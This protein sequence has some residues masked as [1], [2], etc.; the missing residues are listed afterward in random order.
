MLPCHRRNLTNRPMPR[1]KPRR[2]PIRFRR[3]PARHRRS[4]RASNGGSGDDSLRGIFAA[5]LLGGA[6]SDT[7]LNSPGDPKIDCGSA[8]DTVTPNGATD[9][10]RCENVITP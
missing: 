9:V 7:V 4:R 1:R 10:R 2:A 6:G 3:V 5:V 8:Y